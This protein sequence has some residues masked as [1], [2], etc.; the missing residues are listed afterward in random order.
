MWCGVSPDV[1]FFNSLECPLITKYLL[2]KSDVRRME[3]FLKMTGLL[4]QNI[5]KSIPYIRLYMDKLPTTAGM[6]TNIWVVGQVPRCKESSAHPRQ[7]LRGG[8]EQM[9]AVRQVSEKTTFSGSRASKL[10]R[11]REVNTTNVKNTFFLH[12]CLSAASRWG[13]RWTIIAKCKGIL[14]KNMKKC[15]I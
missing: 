5:R 12:I 3:S 11:K 4:K 8:Y 7:Q 9:C 13:V 14:T 15:G 10:Y 2:Y 6:S 1:H